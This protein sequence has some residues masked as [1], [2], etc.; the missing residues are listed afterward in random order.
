MPEAGQPQMRLGQH[1]GMW[2]QPVPDFEAAAWRVKTCAV[3]SDP[4]AWGA[5]WPLSVSV[6]LGELHNLPGPRFPHL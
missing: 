5:A 1:G 3:Q 6:T 2:V 4:L